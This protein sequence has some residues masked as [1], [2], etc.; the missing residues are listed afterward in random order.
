M[1]DPVPNSKMGL[2]DIGRK[3]AD[4]NFIDLCNCV[5]IRILTYEKIGRKYCE[6]IKIMFAIQKNFVSLQPIN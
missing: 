3:R 4:K 1:P 5:K 2:I 6:K